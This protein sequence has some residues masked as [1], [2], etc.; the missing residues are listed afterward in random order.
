MSIEA[1]QC[2]KCGGPL[3]VEEGRDSMYC[4]HCG[5]GLRIT[6]GSS[7]HAMATLA[8]IKEDTSVLATGVALQRL[9]EKMET[10]E[11]QLRD[12]QEENAA[13][14]DI[15]LDCHARAKSTIRKKGNRMRLGIG[16]LLMGAFLALVGFISTSEVMDYNVTIPFCIAPGL[17]F[18]V[19]GVVYIAIGTSIGLPGPDP[20]ETAAR[21]RL[22]NVESQIATVSREIQNFEQRK[23]EREAQFDSLTGAM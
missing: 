10:K 5:A 15:I 8:G 20:Q 16:L 6:T 22:S 21:K 18:V 14:C 2:P 11:A 13:L 4:S 12:L 3:S 1:I 23:A 19:V 17:I 9:D 7:G